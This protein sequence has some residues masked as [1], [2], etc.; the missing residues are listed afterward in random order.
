MTLSHNAHV[1]PKKAKQFRHMF[2]SSKSQQRKTFVDAAFAASSLDSSYL[3]ACS[4]SHARDRPFPMVFHKEWQHSSCSVMKWY[5]Q[6]KETSTRFKYIEHRRSTRR[7]FYHEFLLLKLTD[8]A[9]CK[10]ECLGEGSP[11]N[12]IRLIGI[13]SHD[14]IRWYPKE[15]QHKA[16]AESE[17][18]A[19]V[20]LGQEFDILDVLVICYAVQNTK[21]CS[22]YT[23]QRYNCYFLCLT[24]LTVLVRRVASWETT[25]TPEA[26]KVG[27]ERTVDRISDLNREEAAQYPILRL[28]AM[29]D[30]ENPRP[31]DLVVNSLRSHL[32]TSP[33]CLSAYK[34][35]VFDT[36]W[37]DMLAQSLSAKLRVEFDSVIKKVG[38]DTAH[39]ANH[40]GEIINTDPADA[41]A[42]MLKNKRLL[43]H[44]KT[45]LK[46]SVQRVYGDLAKHYCM[47]Q[48]MRRAE[49]L[50]P[51]FAKLLDDSFLGTLLP[52]YF[53]S[54]KYKT[55]RHNIL[56]KPD[57]TYSI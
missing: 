32:T 51:L 15:Q 38:E 21:P 54:T 43:G 4:L 3:V 52:K 48:R 2:R 50:I 6:Q 36:L 42:R 53:P 20:D 33:S 14:V 37:H 57:I 35:A 34:K 5:D 18:I 30:P 13:T 56:G 46:R 49:N 25:L 39:C 29:L 16:E 8:G 24:I 27:V 41:M 19:E 40:I 1:E 55:S 44:Y 12:A 9:V 23:L 17:A 31:G 26:W 11:M 10:V 7:P 45:A 22:V 47:Y 28:C